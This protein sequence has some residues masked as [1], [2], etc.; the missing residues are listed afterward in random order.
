LVVGG[1]PHPTRYTSRWVEDGAG[2]VTVVAD[3]VEDSAEA[4]EDSA[5]SVAAA[6]SAVVARVGAGNQVQISRFA[7]T[8][9]FRSSG[10][11]REDKSWQN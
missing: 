3:L 11:A 5:D 6:D 7:P 1:P 8:R 2:V 9:R 4:V 10:Q